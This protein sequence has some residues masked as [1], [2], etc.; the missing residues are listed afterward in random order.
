MERVWIVLEG[1]DMT[2]YGDAEIHGVYATEAEAKAR[3]DALN[4]G[5]TSEFDCIQVQGWNVGEA[6]DREPPEPPQSDPLAPQLDRGLA[7]ALC[8]GTQYLMSSPQTAELVRRHRWWRT[9]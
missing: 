1:P 5:T 9:R 3:S 2:Y 8:G 4:G 6:S 7:A